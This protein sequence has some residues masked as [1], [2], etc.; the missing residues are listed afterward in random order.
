MY[1]LHT[2][3]IARLALA[4][5]VAVA[6][7]ITPSLGEVV[8]VE[9]DVGA[10]HVNTSDPARQPVLLNGVDVAQLRARLEEHGAEIAAQERTLQSLCRWFPSTVDVT[11][12]TGTGA[13][14]LKWVGG[15]LAG[16][17]LIYGIPFDAPAVLIIDPLTSTADATSLV[18]VTES[19]HGGRWAGGVLGP[20]G[21]VYG[22]PHDADSVLVIDPSTHDI[23]TTSIVV[24]M[25]TGA[26]STNTSKFLHAVLAPND[27]IY[28]IP[29]S[30]S[31]VLI[32]DPAT[33]A[34]DTTSIA[35]LGDMEFKFSG[36]STASRVAR[37]APHVLIIDT[38]TNTIDTTAIAGFSAG[39]PKW[40]GGVLANNGRIYG[41][42]SGDR[43]VLIIDPAT[44]TAD[45]TTISN[46]PSN[47]YSWIDGVLASNGKIYSFPQRGA[48]VL[49]I[50][51]ATNTADTTTLSVTNDG[52]SG[53][54]GGGRG[55]QYKW[56]G[57][58]RAGNDKLYS[59]P[60]GAENIAIVSP[61]C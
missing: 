16:N 31:A 55:G 50:D 19:A 5:A 17:G 20:N 29:R 6:L 40:R 38:A 9:D 24:E 30:A 21:L 53:N 34:T 23:D 28:G 56:W 46:V 39:V 60:L 3:T 42:P 27:L 14:E 49:V 45:T 8:L 51:P 18:A 13:G 4:L 33:N 10:L 37:G 7:A 15:V 2:S 54:E 35:G 12:I 47:L 48:A 41:I 1:P 22:M 61:G 52:T 58:V 11:T 26:S 57:G 44:D 32:L 59:I 43:S 25:K 36:G